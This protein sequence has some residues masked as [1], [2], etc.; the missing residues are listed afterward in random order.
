MLNYQTMKIE[1]IIKW[2]EDNNQVDWLIAESEKTI[3]VKVYPRKKVVN[4]KGKVVSVADKSQ[5]PTIE[6]RKIDFINLK[7]NFVEKFMQEIAPKAKAKEPTMYEKIQALK[8]KQ[9]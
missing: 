1:D 6:M 7:K 8:N 2:C 3:P 5:E 4:E 9:R